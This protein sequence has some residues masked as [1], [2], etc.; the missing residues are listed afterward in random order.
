MNKALFQ[1]STI[2][3]LMAGMF[4]GTLP[5]ADLLER[6][7][8]GIG[9]FHGLDGELVLLDGVAYQ[10]KVD[11]SVVEADSAIKTPYA[12][13]THFGAGNSFAVDAFHSKDAVKDRLVAEFAGKNTFQAVKMTGVFKDV[14]CRS[15]EKQETPYPRLVDVAEEQAEFRRETVE[16]T[17][18]GFYTPEIF[19]AIAV[20]EFHLHF[21]SAEK[22]FGG[23]VLHFG[24]EKGRVEWEMME[25]LVQD[26][27]V[28]NRAFLE[29]EI[30]Y[31]R[32]AEDIE[33]AE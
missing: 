29:T 17:L 20:P 4:E 18:I 31:S 2:G 24:I 32:L 1:H 12:A 28:G 25:R 16:G 8:M 3:A 21:I 27:P 9:T 19:G 26:F 15:V 5:L 23:H 11:G 33:E 14:L 22:D 13:V 30:D 7:D 6:G 10:I